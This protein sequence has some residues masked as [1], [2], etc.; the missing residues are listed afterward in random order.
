MTP[1]DPLYASQ[2]HF[3]LIG[4]IQRIWD[5]YNGTGI[6]VG[7]Y[8]D[9][10]DFNH[11]DLNDNY[12]AGL[13]VLDNLGNVVDAFPDL[14]GDAHGTACAGLI[15]AEANN[16]AGGVGV[17]WGVDL[18]GVNIFGAGTYGD[19]NGSLANFLAVVNQA[20][21]RFDISSNSWGSTP[22]YDLA[23]QSLNSTGF[24][25]QVS[26]AYGV[27]SS[28]GR[29]GLG[30]I[31]TQAAGN[32][33]LDGNGDGVNASR[34]TVTVAAAIQ[35]G[36]IADYS[37][38]GACILVAAPAASV[39]TDVSGAN[40]YN[41]TDYASD[42]G[43]TSAATPV[44]SGVI[45]L[46]LDANEG[47]GWRDVQNILANSASRTG[48][49]LGGAAS[50]FEVGAWAINR[51]D[52]WN[53]GGMHVHTNYGYGMVNAFNA[54]R[55]AE[56]W[57]LFTPAQTSA[58]EQTASSATVNLGGL[59]IPDNNATGVSF[60]ISMG[61][62]LQIEHAQLVLNFAHTYVGDLKVTLTSAEGTQIVVALNSF[63]VDTNFNG[64][65]TYGIDHLRGELS[66][67]TWTV[68]VVDTDAIAV[69]TLNSASLNIFGTAVNAN[70]VF[71]FTDE[72]LTM[73][74]IDPTRGVINDSDGGIDWM[75]FAAIVP[76]VL[77]NMNS[78]QGFSVGGVT[79]GTLG[80]A[81]V[82]ENAIGG[83]GN[84]GLFGNA[85]NNT[86]YGMRGNDALVGYGANDII[87][88][89]AGNDT[90]LMDD[91][92]NAAATNGNDYGYGDAGDDLL[93][94]YGGN[95][96]LY[97]GDGTDAL[98]GNTF[99]VSVAGFDSLYGGDGTDSLFVGD[100][101]SAY[102]DGGAGADSFF[103]GTSSDTLRGGTGTDYLYGNAGVDFFLFYSTDFAANDAD[104]VYFMDA[105]D[106]L[107]FSS[108]LSG[109]L[110][111]Q[112][113]AALQYDSN[114]AHLTTGVYITAFLAGGAQAHITVYGMTV[115]SLTP[116]VDYTL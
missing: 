82:I 95:D 38:F 16:G 48:S 39:T 109:T 2:W 66:A 104:I 53:G 24:A 112:D 45:A 64:T 77:V 113:I 41:A 85:S 96:F 100:S 73:K 37:N 111:F 107:K 17:A 81:T 103:A 60:N 21:S 98:V 65:W 75:N 116:F 29:A 51:A 74:A 52:N 6:Q 63:N 42:F 15:G 83:D 56:V 23:G 58:N 59:A 61:T 71:H 44:V 26:A 99:Q 18:T 9:G 30:T 97:G 35:S 69:G 101:G 67:G 105:G 80:A 102:L 5:E 87:F 19:V 78:G 90:L 33:A 14:A 76:N 106:R 94:G 72:F 22:V 57:N 88:G 20:A 54:V 3:S 110:F 32:D 13:Q 68:R 10:V 1:T 46:M 84:D 115:A 43:G 50:G 27:L 108:A 79:W 8:D 93:W 25:N 4:N 36:S 91:Y 7:V 11:A 70:D 28:T 31:I 114:P 89:G 55:M 34:Y 92:G 47:L 86:L 40:G 62:N 49:A 12:V